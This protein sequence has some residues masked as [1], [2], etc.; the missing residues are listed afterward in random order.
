MFTPRSFL[1]TLLITLLLITTGC[2]ETE[3]PPDPQVKNRPN[4]ILVITDDQGYGDF[5]VMG[6]PI[7]QTPSIDA[8]AARSAEMTTF[9]VS[10]VCAPTRAN[11]MTGRYNYRTRA[12]DTFIGRAMMEP[13]EVTLAEILRD[14][15]YG[16]GIFGKWHLGDNYPMRAMDQGFQEALVHRGG[17]I[18][19]PSDPPGGE[20]K[21]TD[22]I[23][24]HNGEQVQ[25]T[26]YCTD[27]YFDAA[28]NWIKQQVQ[29]E[30]NFFAYIPTNAPHGPYGDVPP[31]WQERYEAMNLE[32]DQFPQDTGHPL[33]DRIG[34]TNRANI[35]AMI[36]NIDDNMGRLFE[37]LDKL[38]ITD[39][40][41]VIFMTDNGPNGRRY[42]SG[43]R[44][45]KADIYEG[46]IRSPFFAHWPSMLEAGHKADQPVA[47]YDVLPTLLDAARIAVPTG[48]KLDGRS[49]LPLLKG[50][51]VAWPD[52]NL[53]IQTHR[54]N[55]P[56]RY[57]HF[58]TR[59]SKWKLVHASGFPN[60]SF[61]GEP[62]F[63][64]YDME[65]DPLEMNDV[66]EEH[67]DVVVRMRQAYDAWFDDVSNTRPD[68]YAPPRIYIGTEHENPVVLTR[69]DWRHTKG[70]PWAPDSDG[71][72]LLHAPEAQTYSVRLRF[73]A[74]ETAGIATLEF[75]D[76]TLSADLDKGTTEHTFE[77]IELAAGDLQLHAELRLGMVS[78]G[79]WQVDVMH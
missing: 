12:I 23:L 17:G 68:N 28:L 56:V 54:G 24:F 7:I 32:N 70:Q 63:E 36:S 78:K 31:D 53:F 74:A 21:Y 11:L 50:E 77:G 73:P 6:N 19:Q 42:V 26:G 27:V 3:E 35:F 72:W 4:I 69:Q 25:T 61:E 46:G 67:P 75:G 57:H 76:Q 37:M 62:G 33:P 59:D 47:H 43:M 55:Q 16:T 64:L 18:G 34:H 14:A 9:Y 49:F 38:G 40:T 20:D 30:D 15:G 60:E 5:G 2:S 8:M 39:N 22:P 29:Q 48:V 10:P 45:L 58:M 52:R 1:S 41:L 71:F 65:N 13:D 66:A 51:N 44:G 79:P